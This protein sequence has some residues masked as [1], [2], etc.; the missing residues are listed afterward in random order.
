MESMNN[1]NFANAAATSHPLNL[2]NDALYS[3]YHYI[4]AT[5]ER[6]SSGLI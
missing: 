4:E 5:I 3:A 6:D 2:V 1:Y